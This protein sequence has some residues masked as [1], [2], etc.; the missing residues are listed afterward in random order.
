MRR[1]HAYSPSRLNTYAR[2]P[3]RYYFRYVIK[4]PGKFLAARTVGIFLHEALENLVRSGLAQTADETVAAHTLAQVWRKDA[5]PDELTSDEQFRC[6][7]KTL[8]QHLLRSRAD[9]SFRETALLEARLK[10]KILDVPFIGVIDR[11]NRLSDGGLELVDYKSGAEPPNEP[12]SDLLLQMAIYRELVQKNVGRAPTRVSIMHLHHGTQLLERSDEQ[13]H[14]EVS[15]AIALARAI[16]FDE[17]FDAKPEPSCRSCDY[18][19]RC[20]PWMKSHAEGPSIGVA[21]H[22]RDGVSPSVP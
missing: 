1:P 15:R 5:F 8:E 9:E 7:I 16:D 21:R 3:R 10:A 19:S 6:A 13:W 20:I 14:V 12:S 22:S 17:D 18:S 4:A 2:C 11:L